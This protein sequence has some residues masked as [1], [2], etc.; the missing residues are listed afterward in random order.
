M[1][2][3]RDTRG[4]REMTR[5][6]SML[7]ACLMLSPVAALACGPGDVLTPDLAFDDL[8]P[9]ERA[10]FESLFS[11]EMTV[12]TAEGVAPGD[13]F[14]F[15]RCDLAGTGEFA[16]LAFA[17]PGL[18][19]EADCMMWGLAQTENEGWQMM[20]ATEGEVTLA[21]S[22]SMGWPDLIA[23]IEGQPDVV[24]K[25][26]GLSY[27]DTLEGLI[28]GEVFDL[29]DT[30]DWQAGSDGFVGIVPAAAGPSGEAVLALQAVADRIGGAV[31]GLVTGLTDL[32][33]DAVPEVVVQGDGA[34]YCTA[35]G[36][37][38]WVVA[39][40]D[41]AG[42]ILAD[43]TAQ[44]APEIA[45]SESEGYRDIIVWGDAGGTVLRFDGSAYR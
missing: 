31:D 30:T 37:R 15:D 5:I 7:A 9:T 27:R 11:A 16:I 21:G 3:R 25:F 38:V 43:V 44:G 14:A 10:A 32:D 18:F 33:G 41:G 36:C 1:A 20:L 8:T 12:M 19:C 28:Y 22:S 34:D 17:R 2:P 23:R 42:T 29:P 26:D 4:G 24:H 45:A 13:A 39:I 6:L 40:R 35:G